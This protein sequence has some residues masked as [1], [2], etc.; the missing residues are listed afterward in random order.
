[1]PNSDFVKL[2]LKHNNTNWQT[3]AK[4]R[5]NGTY[6]KFE[7]QIHYVF[8]SIFFVSIGLNYSLRILLANFHY[9]ILPSRL[10]FEKELNC[11]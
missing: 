7:I 5:M 1:M 11:V 2:A 4:K 8:H 6:K 3:V 9:V 10:Q